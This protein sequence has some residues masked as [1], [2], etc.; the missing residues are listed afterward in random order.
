MK[1]ILS[2]IDIKYIYDSIIYYKKYVK[3]CIA[4]INRVYY[5]CGVFVFL[6]LLVIV[7]RSDFIIIIALNKDIINIIFFNHF[8]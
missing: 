5:Y 8:S 6:L 1:E 4:I 3:S 7:L 2:I